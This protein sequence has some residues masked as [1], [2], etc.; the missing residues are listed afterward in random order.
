MVRGVNELKSGK[1]EFLIAILLSG[2]FI[3]LPAGFALLFDIQVPFK[4][5][6][7]HLSFLV[8]GL[9]F[10]IGTAFNQGCGVSTISKLCRGDVKMIATILGWLIGWVLLDMVYLPLHTEPFVL[11]STVHY[12]I[13]IALSFI[14]LIWVLFSKVERKKLW[15]SMFG[16]GILAG[17]VFIYEPKWPPSGL[18]QSLSDVALGNVNGDWPSNDRFLL[19]IGLMFGMFIA[20]WR[21]K[22]FEFLPTNFR[23]IAF[24]LIAGIFMGIGASIAK[25]GNDSQLLLA[26]PSL[27]PAGALAIFG[28][29]VGIY[30]GILIKDKFKAH[31]I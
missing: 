12:S 28:I 17:L 18:L 5:S 22:R 21:T 6:N 19:I 11:S 9:I 10:G 3:W 29:V 14:F 1:P 2:V 20:A 23:Q 27:S 13:L 4:S 15:F 25:G 16:I 8:G 31:N 24:H 30:L 7:L 26:L